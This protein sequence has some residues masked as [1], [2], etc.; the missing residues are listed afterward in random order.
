[1]IRKIE[2]GLIALASGSVRPGYLDGERKPLK[3]KS[4]WLTSTV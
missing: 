3:C 1:M 4:G 2:E